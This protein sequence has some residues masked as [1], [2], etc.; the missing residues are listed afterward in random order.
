[1]WAGLIRD[2]YI[3][4]WQKYF[5]VKKAAV[6]FD[7]AAHDEAWV[8]GSGIS[9]AEP[10]A[11][12]EVIA[13]AAELITRYSD[14]TPAIVDAPANAIG[15]WS[16]FE[17][18]KKNPRINCTIDRE[19]V[20]YVKGIKITNTRGTDPVTVSRVVFNAS[21]HNIGDTR[22]DITVRPGLTVTIPVDIT[23]PELLPAEVW[24][25]VYLIAKGSSNSY[26]AIELDSVT[27]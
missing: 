23:L 22:T 19:W 21:R 26:A 11:D 2:F 24:V 15:L 25:Y 14:I 12:S 9:E 6:P 17:F 3:P 1:M 13:K 10:Y 5:E 18:L 4:R 16:P 27:G 20:P 7:F 8:N